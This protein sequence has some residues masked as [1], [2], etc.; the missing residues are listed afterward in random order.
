MGKSSERRE[1][2][3][4]LRGESFASYTIRLPSLLGEGPGGRAAGGKLFGERREIGARGGADRPLKNGRMRRG[5]ILLK[6]R[7]LGSRKKFGSITKKVKTT[8]HPSSISR[9]GKLGQEVN[10]SS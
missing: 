3:E 9:G 1:D 10:A 4:K 2:S 5:K 6:P 7:G 8:L